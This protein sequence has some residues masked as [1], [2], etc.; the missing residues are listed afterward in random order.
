[1]TDTV[2]D[3]LPEAL[4]GHIFDLDGDVVHPTPLARGPWSPNAMHGGPPAALLA[5]VVE[6][7]DPGPATFVARLTIDL[8]RPVPLAPLTVVAR[9]SRPGKKVQ[10][11]EASLLADGVE[12]ARASAL[13]LRTAPDLGLPL[14]PVPG[15]ELPPPSAS[16]EFRIQFGPD[17]PVG[18][19]AAMDVR[20]AAGSWTE[21][22]PGA[23]WF[24]LRVPVVAGE[25]PTPLQ[26]V[27]AAADFGNGVSAAL[28]R[29]EYLFINPDLSIHLHRYPAGEWIGLDATTAAEPVGVGLAVSRLHDE[30]GP[31]GMSLQS[32]LVDRL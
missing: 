16:P 28:A 31:I 22:G 7:H 2:P 8:L 27:T 10:W 17:A 24:R 11:V 15:P 14:P 32:L 29:G 13:R 3:T 26:R 6:R 19:W 9:T 5:R 30:Q 21:P 18:F 1:M 23:V 12:V 20:Q 4:P 25:T